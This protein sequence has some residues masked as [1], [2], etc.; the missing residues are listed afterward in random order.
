[1]AHLP[2]SCPQVVGVQRF[3][4]RL[5]RALVPLCGSLSTRQGR[6]P[7]MAG[8]A[9]PPLAGCDHPR[10]AT[11][12]VFEGL[13]TRGQTAR[14]WVYGFSWPGSVHDEGARRACRVPP[15]TVEDRQPGQPRTAGLGG[16][17]WSDRDAL[18]QALQAILRRPGLARLPNIRTHRQHRVRRLWDQRLLRTRARSETVN[19]PWKNISP[20][21][22]TRH[23]RVTGCIVNVVAGFIAYRPRPKKPSLGL[24]R[25]PLVPM[26]VM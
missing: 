11:H 22:Q 13:A 8:M 23:R 5:P 20:M 6:C 15:G 16:Q 18:A 17:L 3:V 2:P 1:M 24:R 14:G 7:G 12:K 9:S 4:A 10:L 19:D 21:A 25:H 26:L